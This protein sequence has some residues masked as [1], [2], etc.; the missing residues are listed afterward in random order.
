MARRSKDWNQGLARDLQDPEFAR[1]FLIAAIDEGVP[2]QQALGKV[3]RAIGVKEFALRIAMAPS[4]LQRAIDPR[5]NPTQAT[6]NRILNALG[7][8]LSLAVL[9]KGRRKRAA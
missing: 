2:L 6:L 7:L 5:H 3:V 8:R 9:T 1:D 4:N